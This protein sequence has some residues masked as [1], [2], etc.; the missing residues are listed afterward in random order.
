[1]TTFTAS[2]FKNNYGEIFDKALKEPVIIQKHHRNSLVML[3]FDMFEK[4]QQRVSELEEYKMVQEMAEI[5]RRNDF[6]EGDEAINRL[7]KI[8]K[9]S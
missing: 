3:A 6:I 9:S 2:E 4:L 5:K 7:T 1:M 8:L